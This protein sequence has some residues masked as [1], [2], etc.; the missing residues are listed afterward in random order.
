MNGQSF[1]GCIQADLNALR[2]ERHE[3]HA[4]KRRTVQEGESPDGDSGEMVIRGK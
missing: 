2:T 3:L 4:A 1:A